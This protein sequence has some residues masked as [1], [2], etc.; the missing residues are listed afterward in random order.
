[1]GLPPEVEP[2]AFTPL[3]YSA[4]NPKPKERQPLA[5][6]VHYEHWDDGNSK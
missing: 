1:L 3:G 4:D 6:L 2:I 5:A